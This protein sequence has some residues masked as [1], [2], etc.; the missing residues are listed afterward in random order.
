M[1]RS[2]ILS[3]LR[4]DATGSEAKD[5]GTNESSESRGSLQQEDTHF[6][7]SFVDTA[8]EN[9]RKIIVWCLERDPSKRPT[10]QELLKVRCLDH[11]LL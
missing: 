2:E 9:A 5:S 7:S 8:P 1:E 6:P 10:V 4:G 11:I 3:R